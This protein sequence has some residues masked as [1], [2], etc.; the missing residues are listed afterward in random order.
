M[1]RGVEYLAPQE[2]AVPE[3]AQEEGNEE[4][5]QHENEGQQSCIGLVPRAW[6]SL[7]GGLG[8]TIQF[9]ASLQGLIRWVE[10][11]QRMLCEHLCVEKR[12]PHSPQAED[13]PSPDP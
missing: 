10:W 3:L 1:S 9:Q 13:K 2:A 8:T 6:W 4:C 7:C 5:P 11:Q 12:M